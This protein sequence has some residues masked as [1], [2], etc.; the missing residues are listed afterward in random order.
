MVSV[1]QSRCRPTLGCGSIA[2]IVRA[3]RASMPERTVS[4]IAGACLRRSSAVHAIRR[5]LGR[6]GGSVR[7]A[8]VAS[9][10]AR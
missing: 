9:Q 10:N 6:I 7:T 4:W 5:L 3:S 8:V 1:D 2:S